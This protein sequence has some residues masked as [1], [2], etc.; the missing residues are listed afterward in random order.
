MGKAIPLSDSTYL[1]TLQQEIEEKYPESYEH[2]MNLK[3]QSTIQRN[4]RNI[5][6]KSRIKG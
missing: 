4:E 1:Q 5:Q 3:P 2:Y 6:K